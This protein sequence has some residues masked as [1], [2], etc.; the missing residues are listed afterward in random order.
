MELKNIFDVDR[1]VAEVAELLSQTGLLL[2]PAREGGER[3][4][5]PYTKNGLDDATNDVDQIRAYWNKWPGAAIAVPT[6][7]PNGFV[8]M[9]LD[10]KAGKNGI[11]N[12]TDYGADLTNT[13]AVRTPSD[14]MHLLYR[15]PPDFIVQN[16]VERRL[17]SG[18]DVRG[19]RGYVIW[20]PSEISEGRYQFVRGQEP[21]STRIADLPD[22][23]SSR[24]R[25]GTR[26]LNRQ[27]FQR[28]SVTG[29]EFFSPIPLGS[30][31]QELTRRA[32]YLLR[33]YGPHAEVVRSWLHEL[34][35]KCCEPPLSY[36]EVDG[37]YK[38]IR[39]RELRNH[40]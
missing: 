32:G 4:K 37:I 3:V 16:D 25:S 30:R 13:W 2:F 20:P 5:A 22:A 8:V 14:G 36:A 34:N 39:G 17:G 21:W 11:Q 9:D 40:G 27:Q 10:V 24:L 38:S 12:F 18:I 29:Q 15:N 19:E 7:S 33:K 23:I 1:P 28:Q 35:Q 31:N 26:S 6:G